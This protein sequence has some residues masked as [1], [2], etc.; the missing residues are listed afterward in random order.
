MKVISIFKNLKGTTRTVFFRVSA[1]VALCTAAVAGTMTA[2][3]LD[4]Q[5]NVARENTKELAINLT[6]FSAVQSAGSIRFSNPQALETIIQGAVQSSGDSALE[7]IVLDAKG[8]VL[9]TYLGQEVSVSDL[10]NLATKAMETG[11]IETAGDGFYVAVPSLFGKDSSVVGVVAMLWSPD[12]AIS[13]IADLQKKTNLIAGIVFLVALVIVSILLRGFLSKPLVRHRTAMDDVAHGNYTIEV[14]NLKR[15]D[16]IGDIARTLED[17]RTTLLEAE[18]TS[19]E[20]LFKGAA[21]ESSSSA[22]LMV[23]QDLTIN[24]INSA[25]SKI[26]MAN[27]EN[28]SS[29][30]KKLNPS[31]IVG[32]HFSI[33]HGEGSG[34]ESIPE[35]SDNLPH[36]SDIVMGET[37]VEQSIN[38][39]VDVNGNSIGRVIEWKDVTEERLNQAILTSL[40]S[41]QVR[42]EFNAAGE[43]VK[44][45]DNFCRSYGSEETQLLGHH[46]RDV[47]SENLEASAEERDYWP[48][49]SKGKPFFGQFECGIP[50]GENLIFDGSFSPVTGRQGNVNRLVFIGT[51]VTTTQR[52]IQ[53]AEEQRKAS[54]KEQDA[55]VEGLRAGLN[56]LSKG[57][58]TA[59]IEIE[60]SP[61]YEQLRS[62]F[63]EA[64]D[65]LRKAMG[66]VVEN[67]E[68]IRGETNEISKA[69]DDLSRR[70]ETQAATLEQTAAALDEMTSSV[71]SAAE[72]AGIAR[73]MV[74]EARDNA[75]ASG[76]VVREAVA[77][78]SEI[79]SSSQQISKITSVIDEIAFQTNLLALNAGVEAANAGDAGRGFAVVATEVRDLAQRSSQAASEINALISASEGHVKRGVQLVDQTGDAL[80]GIFDRVSEI[81][82]HVG[83]IAVSADEQSRGLAEINIAVNQLDQVTQQNAAMFEETTAASHALTSEAENLATTM[84][85]FLLSREGDAA[86]RP[87]QMQKNE[88]QKPT[89]KPTANVR[90]VGNGGQVLSSTAESWEDF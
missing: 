59:S 73:K 60:F 53:R 24:Y 13:H 18:A 66:S 8:E 19:R 33:F 11:K 86:R 48:T 6:S 52:E 31:E 87:P 62:D 49:L 81:S 36:I 42:V 16:E 63:N 90:M 22:M 26:M 41:S 70:T 88:A 10:K 85:Q 65:A 5:Y 69:A 38:D 4:A 84:A 50:S 77:A 20:S 39:V 12:P 35:D 29:K 32:K 83:E 71:S 14:P 67:S 17:F 51:D 28:L 2:L 40:D 56:S 9:Y 78:M 61:Q 80:R 23:D 43:L 74:I 75:E 76:E 27:Q 46:C 15:K 3:S 82:T 47:F 34:A 44:A 25:F 79:A 68:M 72:G 54:T 7:A 58:L 55:V 21:F 64:I 89:E 37:R 30:L 45:N 1:I 57:D